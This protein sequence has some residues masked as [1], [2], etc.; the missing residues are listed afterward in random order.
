V[1]AVDGTAWP[2]HRL[3]RLVQWLL[4]MLLLEHYKQ[5]PVLLLSVCLAAVA[6]VNLVGR[7]Y[8]GDR[9]VD[10]QGLVSCH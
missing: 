8:A 9:L 6:H 7:R 3:H 4:P 5:M 1:H 2:K 10:G